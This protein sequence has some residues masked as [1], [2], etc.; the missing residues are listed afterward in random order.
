MSVECCVERPVSHDSTQRD[1]VCGLQN[2]GFKTRS[3]RSAFSLPADNGAAD[4]DGFLSGAAANPAGTSSTV[5]GGLLSPPP[6]ADSRYARRRT[7]GADDTTT[8][9]THKTVANSRRKTDKPRK[10]KRASSEL[11]APS[12][13][14]TARSDHDGQL[15]N[16]DTAHHQVDDCAEALNSSTTP[17]GTT[18]TAVGSPLPEDLT[19]VRAA[20]GS[21]SP[22]PLGSPTPNHHDSDAVSHQAWLLANQTTSSSGSAAAVGVIADYTSTGVPGSASSVHDLE[23]A[24]NKHLPT[25]GSTSSD[26]VDPYTG[27]VRPHRS[28][29]QWISTAGSSMTG[30]D[31]TSTLLRSMYPASQRESVIRTNVYSAGTTPTAQR[32]YYP[33]TTAD[34]QSALLT[35]PGATESAFVS[36]VVHHNHTAKTPPSAAPL[37]HATAYG[38]SGYGGDAYAMTPPS[39]VSPQDALAGAVSQYALE[40]AVP[41]GFYPASSSQH[42]H[43]QHLHH[44]HHHSAIK[45][46]H[47][48]AAGV[49]EHSMSYHQ[50]AAAAAMA[51]GYYSSNGGGSLASYSAHYR[52]AM[53]HANATW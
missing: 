50:A 18:A 34:V 52:D 7:C 41:D 44:Y 25:A 53:K 47:Y 13:L 19:T 49:Y 4:L 33:S 23:A 27:T 31:A 12:D 48:G 37:N 9:A 10:R 14:K 45:P 43:S 15:L 5:S 21:Q 20:A 8:D 2:V 11:T 17:A 38:L 16:V 1:A 51:A 30:Q 26:L 42:P 24:M 32:Q 46:L 3:C 36:A 29:I 22:E 6:A 28:A 35:P 40:H 39:S